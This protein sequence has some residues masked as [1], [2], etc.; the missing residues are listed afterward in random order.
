MSYIKLNSDKN[1]YYRLIEGNGNNPYLIFL[2]E[3]LGCSAMWKDYPDQ[4][5]HK[6]KCPGLVYD[7]LGYGKSS[8]LNR[9]RTIHYMHYYALNELPRVIED[10]IPNKPFILIG[11]SDGGSVSLIFG[12]EKP[13]FLKAIITEA[14]HVFVEPETLKGIEAA[15]EAY[16]KGNLKSLLF[17][18]SRLHLLLNFFTQ[19]NF[20]FLQRHGRFDSG[21]KHLPPPIG[22]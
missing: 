16:D 7:R 15:D 2:H 3:G 12:S 20:Q 1:I 21:G 14:A 10:I 8:P 9:T 22:N 19:M 17:V 18:M 4:L 13:A 11:H 6:T 5:C